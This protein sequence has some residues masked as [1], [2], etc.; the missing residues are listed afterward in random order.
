VA[1]LTASRLNPVPLRQMQ[2]WGAEGYASID[3]ARR[4]LTLAQPSRQLR[5]YRRH[6]WPLDPAALTTFKEDLFG[7]HLEL[8]QLECSAPED[9]LTRELQ[10]FVHCVRTGSRPRV[11][12][13]DGRDALALAAQILASIQAHQWEGDPDGPTGPLDLPD[14]AGSLFRPL[15]GQAAA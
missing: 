6:P 15:P 10:D 8:L 5:E 11:S 7:R 4:Q 14:P 9:Q 12:G 1:N 3:F 13:E 2:L